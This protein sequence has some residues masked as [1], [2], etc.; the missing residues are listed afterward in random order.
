MNTRWPRSL[1]CVIATAMSSALLIGCGGEKHGRSCSGRTGKDLSGRTVVGDDLLQKT[2]RCVNL[3]GSTLTG[4]VSE[5]NLRHGNLY[6]ARL[7]GASLENVDL[8]E[9]DLRGADLSSV[10]LSQVDLRGADLSDAMLGKG[11]LEDVS[12][13]G[14]HLS[15][16]D[17]RAASLTHVDLTK[18]DLSGADLSGAALT[19]SDLRGARTRDTDL[20]TTTWENVV[21]PDGSRSNAGTSCTSHLT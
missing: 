7:T 12:F 21:C 2:L 20:S 1:S 15:D 11:L 6:K 10:S 8:R 5:A 4:L 3:E 9:A 17:L 16:V 19:D 18:A 14:A 13:G